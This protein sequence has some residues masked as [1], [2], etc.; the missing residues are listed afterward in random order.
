[1]HDKLRVMLHEQRHPEYRSRRAA[2]VRSEAW[3][4]MLHY[5]PMRAFHEYDWYLHS[6]FPAGSLETLNV[7]RRAR[8]IAFDSGPMHRAELAELAYP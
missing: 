5:N 7:G 3:A 8:V 4:R 6:R 2:M 1:M